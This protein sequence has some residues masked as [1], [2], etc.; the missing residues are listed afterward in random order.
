MTP[1]RITAL[2]I[3]V[4]VA[5]GLVALTAFSLLAPFAGGRY[6]VSYTAPASTRSLTVNSNGGELSVKPTA[7]DRV[8]LNGTA[9]YSFIR[10]TFTAK[11]T[12]GDMAMNYHCAPLPSS[13]CGLDATIG[14]P[15]GLPVNV[16]T[17]GGDASVSRISASVT[18]H[19][20]GGNL[21]ADHITGP[22]NLSTDGGNIQLDAITAPLTASTMGGDVNAADVGS[23]TVTIHTSGGNIQVTGIT[24]QK[25]TASTSGGDIEI[26]FSSV[27]GSVDVNTSGGNI[28]LVLPPGS[29]QY[30]V[31]A[32]TD[33][34]T[35]SDGLV[36]NSA[37]G[38]RITATTGGGDIILRQE[39]V[40]QQ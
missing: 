1:G 30:D 25:V 40:T 18:L 33:G 37:S 28:T 10:S 7:A 14:V 8:T 15:A 24:S 29:A 22:L 32:H 6:H 3:G 11:T 36:H 13:N 17:D 21:S 19:S 5:L 38:H 35:V 12:A 2:L 23:R 27:P 9:R 4:P 16:S 26:V 34:G 31:N 39:T 20:A